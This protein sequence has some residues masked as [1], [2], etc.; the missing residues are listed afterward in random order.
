MINTRKTLYCMCRS[1]LNLFTFIFACVAGK[2]PPPPKMPNLRPI[3]DDALTQGGIQSA[4]HTVKHFNFAGD[5]ISRIENYFHFC[6]NLISL[7]WIFYCYCQCKIQTFAG[8]LICE[9]ITSQI[10]EIYSICKVIS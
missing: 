4:S 10:S 2:L 5:L 1:Y 8:I 6:R 7:N 9:F 3:A